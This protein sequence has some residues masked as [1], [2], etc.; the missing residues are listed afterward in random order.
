M[1][2]LE[3]GAGMLYDINGL[4]GLLLALLAGTAV[5]FTI[6]VALFIRIGVGE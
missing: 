5:I 1:L 6:A 3:K 2:G 4:L